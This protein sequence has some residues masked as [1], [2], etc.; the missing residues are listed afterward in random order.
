M[1]LPIIFTYIKMVITNDKED[2]VQL[3][4]AKNWEVSWCLVMGP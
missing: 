3:F 1:I 2:T 4:S